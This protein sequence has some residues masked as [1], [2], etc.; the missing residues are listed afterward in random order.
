VNEPETGRNVREVMNGPPN[1]YF[2]VIP[3]RRDDEAVNFGALAA[4]VVRSWKILLAT[5]LGCAVIAAGISLHMPKIYRAQTLIAPVLQSN[6]GIG[7]A[8]NSQFG[9]LAALAGLDL[10]GNGPRKEEFFAT[11]SSSSFARDFI[12]SEKLL[13]LLFAERWDSQA[14]QWRK[15][16]RPPT[17]EAGVNKFMKSVRFITEDHRTGLVTVAVEWYTPEIAARWANLMIEM[18]NDRLRTESIRNADRSIDYLNKELAKTNV[19][20]LR[21]VIYRLIENQVNNAM[22]ANVEREYSFR[23]IDPAVPPEVRISPQRTLMAILGAVAGLV[24]GVTGVLLRRAIR[25]TA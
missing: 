12:V 15:G 13:P 24:L 2:V 14:D 23:V 20:E 7:G 1:G 9:G 6:N 5:T 11:L 19:V 17:L 4:I 25:G 3:E 8:L 22:L 18:A 10:G 21:Q 16:E